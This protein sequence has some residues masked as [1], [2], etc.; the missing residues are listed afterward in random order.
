MGPGTLVA[1]IFGLAAVSASWRRAMLARSHRDAGGFAAR[2]TVT[3]AL[4]GMTVS[5]VVAPW[6]WLSAYRLVIGAYQGGA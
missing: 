3:A 2:A 6:V 1:V 4:V 5:F